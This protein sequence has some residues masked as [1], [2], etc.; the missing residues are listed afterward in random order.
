M[1]CISACGHNFKSINWW[2]LGHKLYC[3]DY[4]LDENSGCSF[5]QFQDTRLFW[6]MNRERNGCPHNEWARSRKTEV[7]WLFEADLWH[8]RAVK[9]EIYQSICVT[10]EWGK[11]SLMWIHRHQNLQFPIAHISITWDDLRKHRFMFYSTMK[12]ICTKKF[13]FT[14]CILSDL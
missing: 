8:T 12:S 13:M 7:V 4:C 5:H 10:E 6:G 1:F 11:L 2:N 9:F 3:L 14:W